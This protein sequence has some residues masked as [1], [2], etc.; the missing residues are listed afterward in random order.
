MVLQAP[1]CQMKNANPLILIGGKDVRRDIGCLERAS[2]RPSARSTTGRSTLRSTCST[3]R[4]HDARSGEQGK[5]TC[6]RALFLEQLHDLIGRWRVAL[7]RARAKLGISRSALLTRARQARPAF[8]RRAAV[9]AESCDKTG[10]ALS[11]RSSRRR[12]S[13]RS[14]SSLYSSLVGDYLIRVDATFRIVSSLL[15][16]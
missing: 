10:V 6:L 7:A 9:K 12:L 5:H 8:S 3:T 14:M 2:P 1:L 15:P 4:S 16:R 13:W 11:A